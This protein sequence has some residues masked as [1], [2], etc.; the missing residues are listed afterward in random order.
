MNKFTEWQEAHDAAVARINKYLQANEYTS[1]MNGLV[2]WMMTTQ[3]NPYA[4]L[5][6]QYASSIDSPES[7]VQLLDKIHHAMY[8]DG[9]ICFVTVNGEPRIVFANPFEETFEDAVITANDRALA[10]RRPAS[11]KKAIEVKV[12]NISPNE[13]GAIQEAH[14]ARQYKRS[15]AFEAAR[16]GIERA[17]E[18][19]KRTPHFNESWISECA[20]Q[21]AKYQ[22]AFNGVEFNV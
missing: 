11:M 5:P 12:L 3:S 20:D 17:I 18:N 19:A 13:F 2:N 21:I 16:W 8:D 4:Y 6:V 9:D 10:E 22:K 15:F 1:Q 7:F 14:E